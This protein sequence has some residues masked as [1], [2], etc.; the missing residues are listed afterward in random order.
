MGMGSL[1]QEPFCAEGARDELQRPEHRRTATSGRLTTQQRAV[2]RMA[3]AKWAED[4]VADFYRRD[5]YRIIARNWRCRQGEL[6]IVAFLISDMVPTIV[7]VEVRA[8]ATDYF[9]SP[10]ESV[11]HAKQK[12]LRIATRKFLTSESCVYGAV[13]FDVASVLGTKIEVVQ[14][15]F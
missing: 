5:G 1:S 12:K 13:R 9:G 14:N 15:A 7:V 3:R 2:V 4:L 6:D 10:L 11:T 8:R